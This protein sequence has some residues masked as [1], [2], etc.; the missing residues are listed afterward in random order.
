MNGKNF[1]Y[2]QTG[3]SIRRTNKDKDGAVESVYNFDKGKNGSYISQKV[4]PETG[5]PIGTAVYYEGNDNIIDKEK[6]DE[7]QQ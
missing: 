2:D 5:E 6:Y 1:D 4:D 7:L 3:Y